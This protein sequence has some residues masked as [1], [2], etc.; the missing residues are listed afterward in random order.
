MY[1]ALLTDRANT[2]RIYLWG[3][4]FPKMYYQVLFIIIFFSCK[5]FH[6]S[7]RMPDTFPFHAR[8]AL[9][10]FVKLDCKQRRSEAV[11]DPLWLLQVLPRWLAPSSPPDPH[12]A[13]GGGTILGVWPCWRTEKTKSGTLRTKE[14][15]R[16]GL[17]G[18]SEKGKKAKRSQVPPKIYM[19]SEWYIF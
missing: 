11:S 15:Y 17:Q 7:R 10:Y 8:V 18:E 4:T 13:G 14:V 5:S 2:T 6:F 1:S 16:S 12:L 3:G 9:L 19:D